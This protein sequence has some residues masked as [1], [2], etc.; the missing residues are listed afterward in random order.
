VKH[1]PRRRRRQSGGGDFWVVAFIAVAFLLVFT[2]HAASINGYRFWSRET[3]I[4]VLPWLASIVLVLAALFVTDLIR[5]RR[6]NR[7][8]EKPG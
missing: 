7:H 3:L 1:V 4:E 5:R 6:K 2:G 8:P